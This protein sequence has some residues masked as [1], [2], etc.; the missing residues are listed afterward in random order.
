MEAVRSSELSVTIYRITQPHIPEDN[1]RIENEARGSVIGWGTTLQAG[2]SR[3]Q[4]L[5]GSLDFTVDLNLQPHYGPGVDSASNRRVPGIFLGVKGGRQAFKT[6]NLT[7]I[8]EP[9]VYKMW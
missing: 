6:D 1:Y 8:C 2:R 3:V 5:M 7:A 9:T 4:F